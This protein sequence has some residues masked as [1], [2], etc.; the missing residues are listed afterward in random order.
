MPVEWDSKMSGFQLIANSNRHLK[1]ID[2]QIY[3]SGVAEEN[4]EMALKFLG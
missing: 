1:K 4:A 3:E 2:I